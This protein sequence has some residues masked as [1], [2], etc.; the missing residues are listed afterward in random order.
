MSNHPLG[1]ELVGNHERLRLLDELK[2]IAVEQLGNL[3]GQLFA[4]IETRLQESIRQGGGAQERVDL[5]AL[6]ALR[7]RGAGFVMRYRE[8]LARNFD[9]LRNRAGRDAHVAAMGLVEESDL[10]F[11]VA[12]QQ[13]ADAV[14]RQFSRPLE[15][16]EQRFELL[17]VSIGAPNPA[18]PIGAV[19][20]VGAFQQAF[21]G[22]DLSESLRRLLFDEYQRALLDYL[23]DLYARLNGLMAQDGL[24]LDPRRHATQPQ[25]Q[26][27][28]IP[29]DI[30]TFRAPAET[31]VEFQRL[32]ELLHAWRGESSAPPPLLPFGVREFQVEELVGIAAI[33]QRDVVPG[34]AQSLSGHGRL[35]EAIRAHLSTA[36]L[37]FGINPESTRFSRREQDAIDLVS[38]LFT[39]LV[40]SHAL[41]DRGRQLLSR[42]VIAY[43]RVAFQDELLFMQPGHPARRLLDALALSCESNDGAS[44]QDRALLDRASELVMRVVADYN[45]DLAVFSLAA[46]ELEGM[47]QQQR[48]RAEVAERRTAEAMHGRERLQQARGLAAEAL[49][50]AIAGRALTREVAGFLSEPWLHHAVQVLLRDGQQ[51][52]RHV[53]VV[54]L[55][56]TL[57]ALDGAAGRGVGGP[58]AKGLVN[59]EEALAQCAHSSGLDPRAAE[60]WLAGF[61]RAMAFPDVARAQ[62]EVPQVAAED[63]DDDG[64]LRLVGGT[65]TLAYDAAVAAMM[66][67]LEP[68]AWLRLVDE[69]GKEA[70]VKLAWISPLTGRRLLVDRRGLR[71][72]VASPE[73]M[74]ALAAEGRLALTATASPFDEAMRAVRRQLAAA[75]A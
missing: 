13:V 41:P 54:A 37:S 62:A 49:D 66:R 53:Q 69:S 58:V 64:T 29:A 55:A 22:T 14:A 50:S 15:L 43:V 12:G 31:R 52:S 3:P 32:R 17:C 20:L 74:A 56:R 68:G 23:G 44:P 2:R 25:S 19:R 4:P 35:D 60:E 6:L 51:S 75:A 65:D 42:L 1:L 7:A 46:D 67:E 18:N 26:P 48:S 40:S 24:V 11:H 28:K 47:L 9:D 63:G 30:E 5:A 70:S 16:L 39:S 33:V 72:L 59:L 71:Q 36:A 61:A 73:Q 45:E 27:P 57:V 34:F 10:D 8:L 21:A 38:L